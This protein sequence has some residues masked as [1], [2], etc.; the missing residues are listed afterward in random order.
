VAARQIVS[1]TA[2]FVTGWL[3]RSTVD[4]SRDAFVKLGALLYNAA[5]R[6]RRIFALEQ[7]RMDDLVAE[8]RARAA[9]YRGKSAEEKGDGTPPAR[10]R[11]SPEHS[12]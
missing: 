7:E 11:G 6:I 12:A 10:P 2:G 5:D 3:A 8:A 9:P 4:S 1:F